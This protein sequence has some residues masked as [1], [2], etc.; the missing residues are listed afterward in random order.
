MKDHKTKKCEILQVMLQTMS[1]TKQW[2]SGG[3]KNSGTKE[4]EIIIHLTTG[5]NNNK[6]LIMQKRYFSKM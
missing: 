6:Q 3:E 5:L 4:P 2:E 1:N